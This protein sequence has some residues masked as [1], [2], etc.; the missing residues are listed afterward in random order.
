M[1]KAK[2]M[3]LAGLLGLAAPIDA[4]A[5]DSAVLQRSTAR[6]AGSIRRR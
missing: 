2:H 5:Q 6:P 4:P 1:M 3:F